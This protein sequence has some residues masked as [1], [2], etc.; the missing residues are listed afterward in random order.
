[1]IVKTLKKGAIFAL[2]IILA[3]MF[4]SC[5]LPEWLKAGVTDDPSETGDPNNTKNDVPVS[6]ARKSGVYTI[7]ILN[8]G[9]VEGELASVFI[10]SID[11]ASDNGVNFLQIPAKTYVSNAYGT[12]SGIYSGNYSS[13]VAEGNTADRSR[14]RAILAVKSVIESHFCVY[15]NYYL[16]ANPAM[17]GV[18]AD[19]IGGIDIN[20]PFSMM[21]GGEN[22]LPGEQSLAGNTLASFLTYSGFSDAVRMNV[23]KTVISS[24]YQK[25]K[26]Q[27]GNDTVSLFVLEIRSSVMTDIP[28]SGGEDIFFTR[29]LLGTDG[30][31]VKFTQVYTQICAV[32]AGVPSAEVIRKSSAIKLINEFL[33]VYEKELKEDMFDPEK[34][35]TDNV[36]PLVSIIYTGNGSEL[37][38]YT[39]NNIKD[40]QLPLA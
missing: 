12:I 36:N 24:I 23:Y 10:C 35:F 25:A 16:W 32:S 6:I 7:L 38:V 4:V 19:K 3:L 30:D 39:A 20:V 34:K 5:S 22:I 1:M 9:A 18:L 15:V 31:N 29:K 40:G 8:E 33:C 11:T 2:C 27:V 37:P 17:V 13:A 14:E 21:L 26:S 28:S